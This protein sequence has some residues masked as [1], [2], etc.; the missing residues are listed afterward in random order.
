[1]EYRIKNV[2]TEK[3]LDKAL[4]FYRQMF[5]DLQHMETLEYSKNKWLECMK[6]YSDLMLF[7]E[8]DGEVVGI[9]FGR[10]EANGNVTIEPVATAPDFRKQGL[11]REM[12]FL[13]EISALAN[14]VHTLALG[15]VQSAEGFYIKCGFTPFLF[16][17]TTPPH[18]LEAMQALNT[19]YREVWSY[20][21]GIDIRLMLETGGID[22]ELQHA[23]DMAFP[24]CSTQ[25]VFIKII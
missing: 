14:G 2:T 19:K 24:G 16:I 10:I 1:M 5:A 13:L 22:R 15:A 12:M 4:A 20:D 7:A 6:S 18:S 3:E 8:A 9:V 21:D 11:A 17:Q 23:Y 25:T